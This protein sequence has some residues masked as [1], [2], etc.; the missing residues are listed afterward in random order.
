[1][2]VVNQTIIHNWQKKCFSFLLM[3]VVCALSQ[4]TSALAQQTDTEAMQNNNGFA[5]AYA[6]RIVGDDKITRIILDFNHKPD[7]RIFYM[8]E[9]ARLV[10]ETNKA[11]FALASLDDK[12][13][14]KPRGLV[15][16]M[17]YGRI[18]DEISRFVADLKLPAIIV[19]QQLQENAQLQR[20]RLMLE[21]APVTPDKFG[22]QVRLN[23]QN[24][25][26][27][28]D[29]IKHLVRK[30]DRLVAPHKAD[31]K[32]II[33]IDPGHGGIDSG[34]IGHKKKIKEKVITLKVS[35]LIKQKL[36]SQG[37]F[38]VHL[39]RTDDRF[40]SLPQRQLLVH[41]YQADLMISVHA[42]SL[43]ERYVRGAT[44]YTLAKKSS[45]RLAEQIAQSE[46]LVDVVAGLAA[47][48]AQDAVTDI[49]ADLTLRETTKFSR[50]FAKDVIKRF[51]GNVTLINNPHRSAAFV[52]LKNGEIPG[53]LLELGYLSNAK[54][55][56]ML[57]DPVWQDRIARL[58]ADA[59]GDF[60]NER[61]NV[62]TIRQ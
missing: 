25:D 50:I 3:L 19:K 2:W 7:Y 47:P 38:I 33:V 58:V 18:T 59:I 4:W 57:I 12:D 54:D 21:L 32:F 46:N 28:A 43:K 36:E 51:N 23:E 5:I 20:W 6:G 61:A 40:L 8:N 42:D 16:Q 24:H 29:P 34:A 53:I 44:I 30:G 45:D 9:P 13:A 14:F 27:A 15:H 52:V 41:K 49:L 37:K 11:L 60:F 22:L 31:K 62:R 1:M 17:R 26:R 55:E 35:Q 10:V 56:A 39:T 48:D